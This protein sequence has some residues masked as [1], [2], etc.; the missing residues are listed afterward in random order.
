MLFRSGTFLIAEPGYLSGLGRRLSNGNLRGSIY[1]DGGTGS[2]SVASDIGSNSE[3]RAP[4]Y[5]IGSYN[6]LVRYV[7]SNETTTAAFEHRASASRGYDHTTDRIWVVRTTD[8]MT[9]YADINM[10]GKTITNQ[11]DIRM[12]KNITDSGVN[13]LKEIERLN[14]VNFEWDETKGQ[15]LKPKGVQF[16]IIAQHSPF[17]QMK[18]DDEESYLSIDMSKQ[19]NL[20]S[21]ASQELLAYTRLLEE[22]IEVLESERTSA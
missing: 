21:K 13:A 12:K 17:L 19:V 9:M 5:H 18:T 10:N 3:I 16:G 14:F 20:N 7:G 22:R 11:S 2:I 6:R 4:E 1:I 15:D 8:T